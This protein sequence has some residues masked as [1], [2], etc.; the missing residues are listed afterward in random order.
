[1]AMKWNL[2]RGGLMALV[3]ASAA[4]DRKADT[5]APVPA[6]EP[7]VEWT[8][9]RDDWEEA[10]GGAFSQDGEILQLNWGENL[11][12]IRWTGELPLPPFEIE[13]E[14]RRMDGTDFFC[15][16]TFPARGEDECV[17]LIVGGWGGGLVGISSI[18][19]LDASQNETRVAH[20]FVNETWY[21]IR[22]RREG[23]RFE[24]W[25]D[26]EKL[27]DVPTEGKALALRPGPISVCAPFGLATWQSGAEIRNPRW[28][29]LP[30]N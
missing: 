5:P 25:I 4:C 13:M 27:I 18:D 9:L 26:D 14:A 22:L 30:E 1:M 12:A 15:G 17:T 11:T 29:K 28:R 6:A 21:K 10:G 20:R 23:E 19:G 2:M 7:V 8:E 3:V 16:L 24:V